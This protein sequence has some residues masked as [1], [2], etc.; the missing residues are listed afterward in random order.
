MFLFYFKYIRIQVIYDQGKKKKHK[1][2]ENNTGGIFSEAFHMLSRLEV[3]NKVNQEAGT[4]SY[5]IRPGRGGANFVLLIMETQRHLQRQKQSELRQNPTT[6]LTTISFQFSCSV[7]SN[8][9]TTP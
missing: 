8:F 1:A 5:I 9:F 4:L 7:R 6:F 3:G 2:T